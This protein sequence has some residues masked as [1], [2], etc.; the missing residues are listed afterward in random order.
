MFGVTAQ[1]NFSL[2]LS[3]VSARCDAIRQLDLTFATDTLLP[4]RPPSER[5][6]E[7]FNTAYMRDCL[8]LV[9]ILASHNNIKTLKLLLCNKQML[10]EISKCSKL[11]V[12]EIVE[13][14][15][16]EESH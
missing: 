3:V 14:S 9:R 5:E 6:P 12:L 4:T 15:V 10:Q 16:Q 2:P 7:T 1:V 11:T 13:A 8:G